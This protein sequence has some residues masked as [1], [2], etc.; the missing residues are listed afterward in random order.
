MIYRTLHLHLLVHA[1]RARLN[2][3]RFKSDGLLAAV[4]KHLGHTTMSLGQRSSF[5]ANEVPWQI[6]HLVH[7]LQ[8]LSAGLGEEKP[9]PDETKRSHAAEEQ[10]GAAGGHGEEH[11]R[12]SLGVAVLVDEVEG[13]WNVRLVFVFQILRV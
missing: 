7:G 11:E 10:H 9:H 5:A 4:V 8:T 1:L 12:N 13:H 6:E 2:V 3:L